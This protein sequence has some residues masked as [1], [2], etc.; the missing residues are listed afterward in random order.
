MV[1]HDEHFSFRKVDI[2]DDN[3]NDN[4]EK[5]AESMINI[6]RGY[7]VNVLSYKIAIPKELRASPELY[8]AKIARDF[9][10][11]TVLQFLSGS[12]RAKLGRKINQFDKVWYKELDQ[13]L[14]GTNESVA[15]RD[16]ATQA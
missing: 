15:E 2:E 4:D 9:V 13:I 7:G 5:A 12:D 1:E 3:L 16:E 8:K 10:H 6:A 11:G 14:N